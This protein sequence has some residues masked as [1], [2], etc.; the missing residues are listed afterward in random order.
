MGGTKQI[1]QANTLLL[2]AA[3][4]AAEEAADNS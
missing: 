4:E 1:H 2:Y 3:A